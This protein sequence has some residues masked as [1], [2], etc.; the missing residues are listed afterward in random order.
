LR[1][2]PLAELISGPEVLLVLPRGLRTVL[3]AAFVAPLTLRLRDSEL[4]LRELD[5]FFPPPLDRVL[6]GAALF[7]RIVADFAP[8][9]TLA[10]LSAL[11]TFLLRDFI[12]A[13][14]LPN[15]LAT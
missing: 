8:L 12:E 6:L 9:D 5:D 15:S 1:E 14:S 11:S 2:L 10:L 13:S 4:L 7:L 3:R